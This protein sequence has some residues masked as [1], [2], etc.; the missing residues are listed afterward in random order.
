MLPIRQT[1]AIVQSRTR[2]VDTCRKMLDSIDHSIELPTRLDALLTVD[3]LQVMAALAFKLN[4]SL[5]CF[6]QVILIIT[7]RKEM[8]EHALEGM[9]RNES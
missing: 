9:R 6:V 4:T 8:Y 7:N 1:W 2:K 3:V 5:C